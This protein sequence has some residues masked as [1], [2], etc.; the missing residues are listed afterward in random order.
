M[1]FIPLPE[2]RELIHIIWENNNLVFEWFSAPLEYKY[3]DDIENVFAETKDYKEEKVDSTS[4][5]LLTINSGIILREEIK[6]LTDLLK[7]DVCYIK[8]HGKVIK[9]Y[10]VGNV[11]EL[12]ENKSNILQMDLEFKIFVNNK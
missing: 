3:K 8:F 2:K 7:S 11:N 10:P 9:A 5:T 12:D 6:M 1:K 4:S